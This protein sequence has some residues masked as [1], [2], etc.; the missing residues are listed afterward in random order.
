M[1]LYKDKAS[2]TIQ[3]VQWLKGLKCQYKKLLMLID[4][5]S[6]QLVPSMPDLPPTLI[7]KSLEM[8]RTSRC[9]KKN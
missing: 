4:L 1:V 6:E 3:M 9:K 5:V 2:I 7:T 8:Q